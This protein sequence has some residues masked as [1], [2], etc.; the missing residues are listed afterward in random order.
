MKR[1]FMTIPFGKGEKRIVVTLCR[2]PMQKGLAGFVRGKSLSG[3]LA[4]I[5][6]SLPAALSGFDFAALADYGGDVYGIVMTPEIF[7]GIRRGDALARTC[8]FHELGHVQQRHASQPHPDYSADDLERYRL[9]SEGTVSP[10]ELKADAFAAAYLGSACVAEGLSAIRAYQAQRI[11][12]PAY[13]REA[14]EVAV[15]ELDRRS[16]ELQ[17]TRLQT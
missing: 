16:A 8:L 6:S 2:K 10:Q 12:D 1:Q 15:R 7:H 11:F 3:K 9:A 4:L 13:D 14:V 17:M 5:V